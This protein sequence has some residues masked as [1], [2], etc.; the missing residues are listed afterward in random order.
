MS[1]KVSAIAAVSQLSSDSLSAE[2]DEL[3]KDGTFR[4]RACMRQAAMPAV[5]LVLAQLIVVGF[6]L[7][8]RHFLAVWQANASPQI[9]KRWE[10]AICALAKQ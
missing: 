4:L 7:A 6:Q 8:T 10:G 3:R 1:D 2:Y 9:I 5:C